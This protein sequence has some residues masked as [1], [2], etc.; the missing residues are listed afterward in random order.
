MEWEDPDTAVWLY[1]KN[2]VFVKNLVFIIWKPQ[3][4]IK[5]VDYIRVENGYIGR[6]SLE[7]V[8]GISTVA[9]CLST[10]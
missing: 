7:M 5:P 10:F 8:A 4:Q 3:I 2:M 9:G 6:K 1:V